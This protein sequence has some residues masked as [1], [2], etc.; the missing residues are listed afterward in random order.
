MS[1]WDKFEETKLPPKEA[2]H[3]NL[4]MSDTSEYDYEHAQT[5]SKEFLKVEKLG[6]IP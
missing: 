4:N 2:S 1:S 5:V 3:S 6:R